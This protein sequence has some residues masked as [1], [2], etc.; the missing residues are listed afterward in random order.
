MG[1]NDEVSALRDVK[2]FA[3]VDAKGCYRFAF[4]SQRDRVKDDAIADQVDGI[5]VKYSRRY[6]VQH[7]F[8]I[9]NI[10][11]VPRVW[12]ALEAGDHI[13]FWS[14]IVYDFPFAFITPLQTQNDVNHVKD[15][16]TQ[17]K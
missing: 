9:I 16:E 10:Q 6:L 4:L 5:F 1:R 11:R 15:F 12:A 8:L 14:K 17:Q 7:D 3:K 2:I 13:V